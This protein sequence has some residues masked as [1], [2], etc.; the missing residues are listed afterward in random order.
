MLG[1]VRPRRDELKCRD[2]DAYR[3]A[4][5]GLCRTL[6]ER[7]G[8]LARMFLNYDFTF[9]VMLLMGDEGNCVVEHHRCPANPLQKRCMLL[10]HGGLDI[11]ADETVILS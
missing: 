11:A 1:Y 9:L 6:G 7:Y 3:A 10:R 8:F 2:F 5:C 4:Y